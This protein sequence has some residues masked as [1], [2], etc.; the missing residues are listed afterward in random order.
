MVLKDGEV[1]LIL[2]AAGGARIP[3]AK[4]NVISRVIDFGLTLPN[5]LSEPRVAPD[6]A[7]SSR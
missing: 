4:V 6:R 5:A 1:I 3:P 7:G 2:G